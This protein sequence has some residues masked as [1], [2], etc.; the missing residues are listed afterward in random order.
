MKYVLIEKKDNIEIEYYL[1]ILN[2]TSKE[3][4]QE[5]KL[6]FLDTNFK[7]EYATTKDTVEM[8]IENFL[9][10]KNNNK[11]KFLKP[12]SKT[13]YNRDAHIEKVF[14]EY[15]EQFYN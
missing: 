14:L 2:E 5:Y 6:E 13:I 12:V 3:N 7:V 8:V 4:K 9:D 10:Y 15:E 11:V 1:N